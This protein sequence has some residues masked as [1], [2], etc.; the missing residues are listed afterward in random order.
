M[1]VVT[2]G[3][4]KADAGKKIDDATR[5][6]AAILMDKL[7]TGVEGGTLVFVGDSTFV[8]TIT[9]TVVQ[10]PLRIA[11][12]LAAKYP[13][14]RVL[15]R[16][17]DDTSQTYPAITTVQAGVN[18]RSVSDGIT[19]GASPTIESATVAFKPTDVGRA[20]AGT[21]IP[22]GARIS[23]YISATKVT[24]SANA[25]AAGAGTSI[26]VGPYI[27]DVYNA[28]R[29]GANASYPTTTVARFA[30][31]FPM[32]GIPS[33]F[34]DLIIIDHGHN[35]AGMTTEYRKVHLTLVRTLQDFFPRAGIINL[36]QSPRRASG[37]SYNNDY[38]NDLV[39]ARV[40][41]ALSASE[42]LGLVNALDT[43]LANPDY[44][45]Q[46]LVS[47]GLHPNAAGYS[48]IF[49]LLWSAFRTSAKNTPVAVVPRESKMF[50]PA[51][52]FD[53]LTGIPAYSVVNGQAGAWGFATDLDQSVVASCT[54]PSHW[55]TM[56]VYV[57]WTTALGYASGSN[58]TVTWRPS[59]RRQMIGPSDLQLENSVSV[60]GSWIVG[61][62]STQNATLLGTWSTYAK[63]I[64]T[65]QLARKPYSATDYQFGWGNLLKIERLGLG[66]ALDNNPDTVYMLGVLLVRAS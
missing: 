14:L 23:A 63:L 44:A 38:A 56:D 29:S 40:V 43:F 45:T 66:S 25:T 32:T 52:A 31:M 49:D 10:T 39:R 46:W 55:Q 9:G 57:V 30:T 34:P 27:L 11:Q 41:K 36:A 17:W 2:L 28:S 65:D 62:E 50:I 7:A 26:T 20:I 4:A 18:S 24:I 58:R 47:D 54:P 13:A 19:I 12:S 48:V 5:A 61:A 37:D 59:T 8:D 51:K 1:D 6:H 22:A 15:F 42:G 3:M 53:A 33:S 16:E 64:M 21:N 60:T 35:S